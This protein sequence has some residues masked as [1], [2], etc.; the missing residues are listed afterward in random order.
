MEMALWIPGALV[1]RLAAATVGV[2]LVQHWGARAGGGLRCLKSKYHVATTFMQLIVCCAPTTMVRLGVGVT[3]A[4][5]TE[6]A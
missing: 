2:V 6:A 1:K 5:S 3:V 4:G